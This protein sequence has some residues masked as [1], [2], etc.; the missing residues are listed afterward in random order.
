MGTM[1]KLNDLFRR[2]FNND[3]IELTPQT[4]ANDVDGWDSLSHM[5]LILAIEVEFQ[6]EF[7]QKEAFGFQNVGELATFINQ[8]L[9]T[10]G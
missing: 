2:V 9:A 8:K 10:R 5:N 1:E 7:T 4:T 3:S 6:I